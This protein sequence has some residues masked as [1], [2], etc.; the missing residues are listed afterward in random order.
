[1]AGK[2]VAWRR[3]PYRL[4][5]AGSACMVVVAGAGH[6][7]GGVNGPGMKPDG[8]AKPERLR[9]VRETTTHF[10][11][12]TLKGKGEAFRAWLPTQATQ[13]GAETAECR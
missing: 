1:M 8:D 5:P 4:S 3:D 2:G 13:P 7:L 6:Y 11:D 12:A 10:L 9:L